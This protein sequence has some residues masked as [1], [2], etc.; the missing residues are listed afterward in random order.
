MSEIRFRA[1]FWMTS[2]ERAS[3]I[4]F[5]KGRYLGR[6]TRSGV[7]VNGRDHGW[8]DLRGFTR[9][10][11]LPV[12]ELH[13]NQSVV[14]RIQHEFADEPGEQSTSAGGIETA[15]GIEKFGIQFANPE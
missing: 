6:N 10:I 13:A 2:H 4:V 12:S 9:S 1:P 7:T 5:L 11:T 3:I 15:F 8:L 14:V